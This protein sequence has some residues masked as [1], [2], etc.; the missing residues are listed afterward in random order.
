M[1]SEVLLDGKD[2]VMYFPHGS[3]GIFGKPDGFVQAVDGVNIVLRKGQTLGIVGE[4]GC[5]KSTLLYGI[6]GLQAPSYGDVVVQGKNLAQMSKH[7]KAPK[8]PSGPV[9]L[10]MSYILNLR[11]SIFLC[12]SCSL[13]FIQIDFSH[14]DRLR[15]DF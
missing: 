13:A 9:S 6:S 1:N 11:L 5:G 4:S 12:H 7:E 3:K 15:S 14:S 2:L 8:F 10:L